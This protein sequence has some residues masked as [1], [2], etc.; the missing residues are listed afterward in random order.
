MLGGTTASIWQFKTGSG[1]QVPETRPLGIDGQGNY[2]TGSS[3]AALVWRANPFPQPVIFEF[4]SDYFP[5]GI[6]EQGGYIIPDDFSN[7]LK[8]SLF[9]L[10]TKGVTPVVNQFNEVVN[11]IPA[12]TTATTPAGTTSTGDNTGFSGGSFGGGGGGGGGGSS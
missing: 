2:S 9:A 12:T 10:Q 6:G 4:R 7:D 11:F 1:Y 5:S 8:G 3:L